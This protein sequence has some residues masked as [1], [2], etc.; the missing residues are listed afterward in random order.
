M[1]VV[2]QPAGSKGLAGCLSVMD[3]VVRRTRIPL[4]SLRLLSRPLLGVF[5]IGI[6]AILFFGWNSLAQR[7]KPTTQSGSGSKASFKS[8]TSKTLQTRLHALALARQSGNAVGIRNASRHVA[9]L[10][11]RQ[12][13]GLRLEEDSTLQAVDILRRSVDFEDTPEAH[14]DL[15]TAF[16]LAGKAD[17]ALSHATN[18]VITSPEIA[19]AW[20]VQGQ[21]WIFKK[22][23]PRAAESLQRSVDLQYD[24]YSSYLLGAALLHQ[25]Q[26]DQGKAA[27]TNTLKSG[28]RATLHAVFFDAYLNTNYPDDAARELKQASAIDPKSSRAHYRL[29]LLALA[30]NEWKMTPAAAAEFRKQLEL[31]GHDFGG[32]Y[33]LGL[34]EFFDEHYSQAVS[35]LRQAATARPTWPEPWLY[36][37]LAAYAGDDLNTAEENLQKAISLTTDDSRGNYQIRRAYYTLGRLR[38]EQNRKDEATEFASRFRQIQAKMLLEVQRT[39]GTMTG[40]MA[41]M[42]PSASA[43]SALA[44]SEGERSLRAPIAVDQPL[45]F[46]VALSHA[47]D[48]T[49]GPK[50][51]KREDELREILSSAL[52]DLGA[53]EARQEQF[54]LALSHFQEA[55]KWN[56]ETSGLLRNIG[57]AAARLS[58]Y[59]ETVRTLRPLVAASPS[60]NVARSMLALALFSTNAFQEAVKIFAPL[61]D[62]VLQQPELAYA[63]AS[64]LVHINQFPKA[65]SLLDKM[66]QRPLTPE[67]L[68]LVAQAWSQMGNYPKTVEACHQALLG[69]PQ[70]P[71]AHYIAGLALIHQD[72]PAEAAQEFRSE[73]QL[74]PQDTDAQFHLAFVL[75]QM[76]QNA[77]AGQ[78][79]RN[80]LAHSP[81][82]PEAN[83][84]FGKELMSEGKSADAI[85]YLETAARLKPQFEPVHYQLQSAYRAS[86]RK[87]DADRE[88]KIYKDLKAKSRNITLPPPRGQAGDSASDDQP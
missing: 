9:A 41:Q 26:R 39:P 20:R 38:N 58:D 76:S 29:G 31:N 33:A 1:N 88:A 75:L 57:M 71:R 32:N 87:E 46:D 65:A 51:I 25:M 63:W 15:A 22:N 66:Q 64:S 78:L 52:N 18:V 30:R 77:E 10:S 60:D 49:P 37:G 3:S 11:L 80:V 45:P 82:H 36:L 34:M 79:L 7:I 28:N 5:A 86:G 12:I 69:K 84:E 42:S 73:L 13:G 24:P 21:V 83:Y 53:V 61:G 44:A 48:V 70:L 27:F 85:P 47:D 62:S 19:R 6:V 72:R 55:E 43:F 68:I 8:T 81:E 2:Y 74:S 23:Y 17:D 40:G 56:S 67:T 14:L 59:K 50:S 16:L 4:I 35:L 54:A